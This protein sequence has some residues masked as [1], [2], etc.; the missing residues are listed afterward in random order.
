MRDALRSVMG[1]SDGRAALWAL[2][3]RCNTF[4]GSYTGDA[5]ST[6][7]AEGRRSVGVETLGW[8][9]GLDPGRYAL[10]LKEQLEQATTELLKAQY[11]ADPGK[12]PPID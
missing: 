2:L 11:E 6:A 10:M 7:Y 1:T 9:Q 4:G 5:F 12:T 3:E 8:L